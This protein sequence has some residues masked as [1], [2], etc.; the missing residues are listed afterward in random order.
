M[1][2]CA[3]KD[4]RRRVRWVQ[5]LKGSR[6]MCSLESLKIDLK[7]LSDDVTT[8]TYRLSDSY[9]EA[10]DAP[11][12]RRGDADVSL[13]V[14][15]VA[16]GYFELRFHIDAEVTVACDRCLDDMRQPV[17][18]DGQLTARLGDEYSDDED[19]VTVPEDD[20][21]LDVAWYIYEFIAL[22]IPIKHVHA[23]GQCNVAM[24]EAL[25]EHSAGMADDAEG[26]QA[27]DPRWSGLEKLKTIIKD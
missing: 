4:S 24:M 16:G 21:V 1:P 12:V 6:Q 19:L 22:G 3:G 15:K 13:T 14:R 25:S 11:E 27:V 18:A 17:V 9:F 20:G 5:L 23:D 8:F 10:I 26:S 2:A 7:G